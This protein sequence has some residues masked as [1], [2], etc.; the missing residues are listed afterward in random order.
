L[1]RFGIAILLCLYISFGA[2][3]A[4]P[5]TL[6]IS[7]QNASLL[8]RL[9]DYADLEAL[10]IS[11]IEKLRALPDSIGTLA[12][13]KTLIIDNGNGCSMNP[14][15]PESI[16]NLHLLEKL[17][18]YGAQDP[19]GTNGERT[20]QPRERHKFPASMSQL[21][22]LTYL[23]LG[24]N[25]LEEIPDFV[26]D[27]PMLRELRFQWNGKF[28]TVPAF[29]VNLH[30]LRT[31][32]LDGNDL[33]DVPSFLS[34]LPKLTRV[35]LGDNCSITQSAARIRELKRRFPKIVFDF[36]DEY[37]CPSPEPSKR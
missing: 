33:S 35:S 29:I 21:K 8:G 9:G 16:G 14:L 22:N 31:L 36:E 19:G 4:P 7:E 5:Q 3:A 11:C 23:D 10:S 28:K 12:K 17:V 15:L 30:E 18:L 37:D 34:T 25:A 2:G 32:S 20:V 13:L 27:L 1:T 26:K 24:R 6:K